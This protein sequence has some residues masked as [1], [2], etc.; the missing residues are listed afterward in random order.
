MEIREIAQG[1]AEMQ[2]LEEINIEAIPE[3]ERC[4]LQDMAA[5]G[6]SV[7]CIDADREP[8]GFMAV[9]KY[10]NLVYLAYFAVRN[11]LR[12]RGI[13]G[14]AVRALTASHPDRQVI[15]E[16]EAPDPCCENNAMR[17]RRKQFYLRNGFHETG[18]HTCY[19]GTEFEVACSRTDFD[20]DLFREFAEELA[21]IVPDYIP[22]PFRKGTEP[23]N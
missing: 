5:T 3:N 16:Y 1:S 18:W 9:R 22:N 12:G 13:G 8:A 7:F 14:E 2:A 19:D 17:I 10:R 15:V 21:K 6:A 11:D 20:P 4:S 23:G